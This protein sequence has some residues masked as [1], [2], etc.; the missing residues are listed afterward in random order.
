MNVMTASVAKCVLLT[1][2]V[3]LGIVDSRNLYYEVGPF[4]MSESTKKLK[5]KCPNQ[6]NIIKRTYISVCQ[7]IRKALIRYL[8]IFDKIVDL[9]M[10]DGLLLI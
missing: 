1:E 10:L 4:L 3:K 7:M 2:S 6:Q 9:E 5:Y 8:I